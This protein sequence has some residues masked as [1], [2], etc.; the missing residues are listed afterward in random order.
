MFDNKKNEKQDV[1]PWYLL[2][3]LYLFFFRAILKK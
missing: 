1:L 2:F 3:I